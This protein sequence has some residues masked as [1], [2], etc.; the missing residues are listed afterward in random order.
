MTVD[1]EFLEEVIQKELGYYSIDDFVKQQ[2]HAIF[3][4]KL[5]TTQTAI[6]R[7]EAKYRMNLGDFQTRIANAQDESL[8]QFG[9]IEKEDDLLDWEFQ[10]HALPYYCQRLEQLAV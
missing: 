3:E 10:S 1:H 2:A 5:T 7:Y 9:L 8:S 6:A 4:Q